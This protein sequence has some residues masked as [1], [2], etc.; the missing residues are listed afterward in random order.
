MKTR[1]TMLALAL[2]SS[3]AV[4]AQDSL[5]EVVVTAD[6]REKNLQQLPASATVLERVGVRDLPFAHA[7]AG[8]HSASATITIVEVRIPALLF[9]RSP[10]PSASPGSR[11][12]RVADGHGCI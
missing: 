5:E 2:M 6:L 4:F 11:S 9:A 10:V 3:G 12:V 7:P 8:S 1:M